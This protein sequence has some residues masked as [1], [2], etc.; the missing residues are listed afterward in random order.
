MV[1][2]QKSASFHPHSCPYRDPPQQ[3]PHLIRLAVGDLCRAFGPRSFAAAA[4]PSPPRERLAESGKR[5]F[6]LS[7]IGKAFRL[8]SPA[9]FILLFTLPDRKEHYSIGHSGCFQS[10]WSQPILLWVRHP[11]RQPFVN[12]WL[13]RQTQRFAEKQGISSSR[14]EQFLHP[15]RR[16]WPTLNPLGC[17]RTRTWTP[18]TFHQAALRCRSSC[19]PSWHHRPPLLR[20]SSSSSSFIVVVTSATQQHLSDLLPRSVAPPRSCLPPPRA[21]CL[22]SPAPIASV[23]AACN[24]RA[25][26]SAIWAG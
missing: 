19:T 22:L 20:S 18:W 15:H 11:R 7:R 14:V 4:R 17:C 9:L 6:P 25:R 23:D 3:T 21:A 24:G 12:V 2:P 16:P 1:R 13:V 8:F 26:R 10:V 5:S